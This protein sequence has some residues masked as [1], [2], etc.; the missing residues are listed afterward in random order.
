[1]EIGESDDITLQDVIN[2]HQDTKLSAKEINSFKGENRIISL[3]LK[4]Q[5]RRKI[6]KPDRFAASRRVKI[7]ES[8]DQLIG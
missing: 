3:F 8:F 1:M 6:W 2:E 4:K 5:G 7:A